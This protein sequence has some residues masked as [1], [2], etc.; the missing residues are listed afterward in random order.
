MNEY[1]VWSQVR[2]GKLLSGVVPIQNGVKQGDAL[3]LQ[4][5]NFELMYVIKEVQ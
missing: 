2:T 3:S 4:L 1:E 5:F